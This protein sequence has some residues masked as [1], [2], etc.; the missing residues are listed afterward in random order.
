MCYVIV[1]PPSLRRSIP[2]AAD[3]LHR[4]C[5][6]CVMAEAGL[7]LHVYRNAAEGDLQKVLMWLQV[8]RAAAVD[9]RCLEAGGSCLLHAASVGG[10]F[11]IV[12]ELLERGA[13]VDARNSDGGTALMEACLGSH[14]T[15]ALLLLRPTILRHIAALLLLHLLLI[16]STHPIV[17]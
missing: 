15:T 2:Q 7:E 10:Q 11:H 8:S 9:A 12:S 17:R 1:P 13:S 4:N 3:A 14:H 5:F 16:R 6:D